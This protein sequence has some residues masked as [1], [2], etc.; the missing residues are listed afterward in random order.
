MLWAA[1]INVILCRAVPCCCVAAGYGD[2]PGW[3]MASVEPAPTAAA[4]RQLVTA[5][6]QEAVKVGAGC[7]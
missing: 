5:A 1:G 3:M 6:L 2:C 4:D 7:D